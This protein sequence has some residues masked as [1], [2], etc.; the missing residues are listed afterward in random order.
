M[1]IGLH[2]IERM[3]TIAKEICEAARPREM[4]RET[5]A[6]VHAAVGCSVTATCTT[7]RRSWARS[8]KTNSSRHVTVGTTKKSAAISCCAWLVKNV[9]QVCEGSG[10]G[11]AMYVATVVWETV[12]PELQQLTVNPRRTPERI[13][14]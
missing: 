1:P 10:W 2:V 5:A 4:R 12:K 9:R 7:R 3:I 14:S 6:T 11:Q 8:T 13:R